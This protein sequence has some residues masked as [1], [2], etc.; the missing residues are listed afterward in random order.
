MEIV[1]MGDY[2]AGRSSIL[3]V[4][5]MKIMAGQTVVLGSTTKMD[6][7]EFKISKL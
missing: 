6:T 5:F 2:G 7:Y 3:K 1:L 4:I